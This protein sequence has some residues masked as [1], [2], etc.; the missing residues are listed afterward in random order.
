MINLLLIDD[1]VSMSSTS[2]GT[3]VVGEDVMGRNLAIT[4]PIDVGKGIDFEV[5]L[6]YALRRAPNLL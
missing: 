3:T 6:V 2:S 5:D 4:P 1:V